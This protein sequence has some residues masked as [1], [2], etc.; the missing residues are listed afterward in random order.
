MRN[1]K[2]KEKLGK[3]KMHKSTYFLQH[4]VPPSSYDVLK[5]KLSGLPCLLI[6]DPILIFSSCTRF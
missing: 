3:K 2:E 1:L 4:F 6:G 5:V